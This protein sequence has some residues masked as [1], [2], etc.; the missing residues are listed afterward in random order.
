MEKKKSDQSRR[1][2]ITGLSAIMVGGP[3][4]ASGAIK[5]DSNPKLSKKAIWEEFSEEEK[6]KIKKSK[7][8]ANIN[9]YRKANHSCAST[10]LASTVEYLKLDQSYTDA[11]ASYGGGIGK[12]D[13]CG[14]L[15]GAVMGLGLHAGKVKKGRKEIQSYSRKLSNKF[16]DWW[17]PL[18]PI[19]C[20]ELRTKYDSEGFNRMMIRVAVKVEE[21]MK[22]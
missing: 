13:L 8:A 17:T 5:L 9:K 1:N 4:I 3:L 22:S 2:F 7:M 15:T 12:G 6:K 19:H 20:S 14:F 11:A 16:W 18:A 21:L 10:I